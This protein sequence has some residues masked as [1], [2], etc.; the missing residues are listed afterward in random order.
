MNKKALNALKYILSL[1]LAIVLVYFAF[2]KLNWEEFLSGL[3]NTRWEY[4]ALFT[5]ASIAAVVLRNER[6]RLMML[7]LDPK[8]KRLDSW[9]ATNI[10]NV[11]NLAIPGAGEF[12]RCG[13]MSSKRMSYGTTFGTMV[14][15]RAWDVLAIILLILI[16]FIAKWESFGSFFKEKVMGAALGEFELGLA[17]VILLLLILAAAGIFTIYKLRER[18]KFCSKIASAVNKLWAGFMSFV[19][20]KAKVLFVL[21]TVGIWFSYVLMTY[22]VFLAIPALE[23]LSFADA[24]L[25]SAMGNIASVIPV[26]G[27]IGAY[28]YIVALTLQSIYGAGWETGILFATLNHEL[29][30]VLVI[31]MGIISYF[32]LTSSRRKEN[33]T[34][35]T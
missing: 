9:D 19:Q 12:L 34:D 13:Y 20:I 3:R 23:H 18:N 32:R 7:P 35:N 15:E 17:I 30:A 11:A 29:H 28:H 21:Y 31:V 4:I 8:V 1:I 5:L 26:P 16:A 27:G 24:I 14:C 22:F 10:G 25:I 6:W 2:S 33:A